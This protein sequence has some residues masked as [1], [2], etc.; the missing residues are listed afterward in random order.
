[1]KKVKRISSRTLDFIQRELLRWYHREQRILPWRQNPEPYRVWVSEIM[2]QQTQVSKVI[3]Y[4]ERFMEC[5]PSIKVLAGAEEDEVLSVWSG[6]GYYRRARML[7]QASKIIVE[8]HGGRFPEDFDAALSLPGLGRYSVGAVLSIAYGLDYPVVDGNVMRVLCRLALVES[9]PRSTEGQKVLWQLAEELLPSGKAGDFNQ[10]MME[11]GARICTPRSPLCAQCPVHQVCRA[12]QK[13]HPAE[14][15]KGLERKRYRE[16]SQVCALIKKDSSF[17]QVKD[18]YSKWYQ[19]VWHLPVFETP[20]GKYGAANIN[21]DIRDKFGLKVGKG[22]VVLENRFTITNHRVHQRVVLFS[23]KEGRVT[24]R[25]GRQT[26]WV[27]GKALCTK[28]L[29]SS[30]KPIQKAVD[31]ET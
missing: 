11:L 6:L 29:P 8:K 2:L 19:G 24:G 1:M 25:A 12:F 16:H 15:P 22:K 30:Q 23:L 13:G 21:K 20:E 4:Y 27:S 18:S 7:H 26:R 31:Q 17:L 28:P 14:Y 3:P 5:F 10:A 9:S